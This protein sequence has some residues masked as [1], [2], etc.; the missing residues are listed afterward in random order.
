[1]GDRLNIFTRYPQAGAVKTRLIP[2]LGKAGAA[3]MHRAMTE[4]TVQ[5]AR[6]FA[7]SAPMAISLWV[8]AQAQDADP[9]GPMRLWLGEGLTYCLQP[10][11]DLGQRMA[12]AIGQALD[13]GDRRVVTIGTDCPGLDL[14][15]LHQ[16]F[17][18]LTDHD[19]VLG[20]ATDGGYYL[21]GLGRAIPDL[22]S[23]IAW[24]TDTV[25]A[26]TQAIAAQRHLS[27]ALLPPLTD[28]DRPED[29]PAWDAA[30]KQSDPWR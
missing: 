24:G 27:V 4:R 20:P 28:V 17:Q 11:G 10:E 16:A 30:L 29:L 15:I 25:L 19:L 26:T 21:I 8:A 6:R 12:H 2:A 14:P 9:L 23:G 7:A 22:F 3:E 18:A 5:T 1:M 13:Q